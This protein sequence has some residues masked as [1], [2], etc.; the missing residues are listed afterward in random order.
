MINSLNAPQ[1]N[2]QTKLRSLIKYITLQLVTSR[3]SRWGK[4]WHSMLDQ[5]RTWYAYFRELRV[6][7]HAFLLIGD[8]HPNTSCDDAIPF[9]SL[10]HI[11]ARCGTKI[12]PPLVEPQ[13]NR[14]IKQHTWLLRE[15]EILI[16]LPRSVSAQHLILL[17]SIS[18]AA[19]EEACHR[20]LVCCLSLYSMGE[21]LRKVLSADKETF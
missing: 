7:T 20:H 4:G 1:T 21:Q 3:A 5:K 12:Q 9:M 18:A 11:L 2:K 16:F 14:W 15:G 19:R 10:R 8:S 17:L 6:L 13:N